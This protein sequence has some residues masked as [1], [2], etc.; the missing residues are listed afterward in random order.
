MHSPR[1]PS[2]TASIWLWPAQIPLVIKVMETSVSRKVPDLNKSLIFWSIELYSCTWESSAPFLVHPSWSWAQVGSPLPCY[3][4]L[5]HCLGILLPTPA[6]LIFQGQLSRKRKNQAGIGSENLFLLI[7]RA[8]E[9]QRFLFLIIQDSATRT[10]LLGGQ[11][12]LKN[13]TH[14]SQK[15]SMWNLNLMEP[16]AAE[17]RKD[18]VSKRR[19]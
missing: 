2:A 13:K 4:I 1:L 8:W 3:P 15:K 19:L 11:K 9:D 10:G 17:M 6:W 7:H 14:N 5:T 12:Y 16:K 18:L